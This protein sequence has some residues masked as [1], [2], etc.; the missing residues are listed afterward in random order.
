MD[1]A[2]TKLTPAATDP[3]GRD[4]DSQP[5]NE[6]WSYPAA[7]GTVLQYAAL[8]FFQHKTGHCLAPVLRYNY[9]VSYL[10]YKKTKAG[11]VLRF[12]GTGEV[13]EPPLA[14]D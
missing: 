13:T 8:S 5:F 2:T 9:L 14:R 10:L 6:E 11:S 12:I 3:L 4:L 7:V 1:N